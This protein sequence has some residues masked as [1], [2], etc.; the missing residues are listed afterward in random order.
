MAT[1][2]DGLPIEPEWPNGSTV[3]VHRPDGRVLLL[4]RAVNGTDFDGDWAWTPPAGSRQPGEAI[5]QA[6]LREL[7]EE[8]GL[9]GVELVPVDLSGSWALFTTQVGQDST[10]TLLDVEHDRYEWVPPAQAYQRI[11]PGIVSGD[12]K[13]AL[14]VPP[15]P[16]AFRPLAREDFGHLVGWQNAPHVAAWWHNPV[17]D[18]AAAEAKYGPRVAGGSRTAVDVVLLGGEPVGF[19]QSTRL[20]HDAEYFEAAQHATH[21][22]QETICIDYA[23][24]ESALAGSGLGTRLIW[25]YIHEVVLRRYP[26]T[27]F[28]VA[29][30]VTR[31]AASIRACEKAG[32]RRALDYESGSGGGWHAL[33]VWS[34]ERVLGPLP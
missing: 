33:C 1:T 9:T 4:H 2:W 10:V 27:R 24:G 3:V 34:R 7:A 31:N 28:V 25:S 26:Q 15:Q 16:V 19:I 30:P 20:V 12:I 29:D 11:R 22:G 8:S 6:T 5:V 14:R 23:I 32:F 17:A 13:R 21:G 18:L